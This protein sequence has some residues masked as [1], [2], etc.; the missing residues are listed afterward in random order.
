MAETLMDTDW[1]EHY[2]KRGDPTKPTYYIIRRKQKYEGLFF[3]FNLIA[4][5]IKH[6]LIR[7]WLPVVDMQN[8]PNP[9]LSPEK[10]GK[11]N[12]WEYYFEQPLRIGLEQA[13]NGDNIIL[14]IGNNK[15]Q[16]PN[17]SMDYFENKNNILT[18]WRMLVK[19]GLL[20]VKPALLQDIVAVRKKLFAPNDRV[21]GVHLRGTDYVAKRPHGHAIP[22]PTEFAASIVVEKL[23]KWR[24]NKIFLATEDKNI[25]QLFKQVFRD[26]CVT[27]DR[28]Y[29][30]YKPEEWISVQ[31]IDRP[32]DYFL[33]G[34]EYL[35]DM[36]L[37][38]MCNSLVAARCGGSYATVMMAE[39]FEHTYFF[40]LGRYGLIS[41]D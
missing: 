32:N 21:L 22:P 35:T 1:S 9:S 13:Y 28:E 30:D 4:G 27:L 12:A 24:C 29:V 6:A 34:K 10:F 23:L 20:K 8:Y 11:E 39:N 18:E 38:S 41:L 37:L 3:R 17:T 15:F 5:H 36:I 7:G 2:I 16:R 14:S 25:V 19:L 31:R 33:R 26:L 40:N